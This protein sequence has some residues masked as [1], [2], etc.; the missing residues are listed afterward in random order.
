MRTGTTDFFLLEGDAPSKREI[1]RCALRLFVRDGL[2][3]TS[4]RAIAEESGYTNPALY[5]FF[6]SK[7]ALA[8]HLFERCYGRLYGVVHGAMTGGDFS[9]DLDAL[10]EAFVKLVDEDLEAVLFVDDTLR[11]FWPR[12]P[13]AARSRSLVAEIHAL[14]DRGVAQRAVSKSL[15]HDLATALV[16]GTMG[17]VARMAYFDEIEGAVAKRAKALRSLLGKALT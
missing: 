11:T 7:E 17:Q 12:L 8:L 13:K 6:E 5:K 15:D 10:V 4:I 2:C 14:I 1:L 3:E 9:Q 16:L